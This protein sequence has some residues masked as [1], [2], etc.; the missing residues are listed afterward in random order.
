MIRLNIGGTPHDL[1]AEEAKQLVLSIAREIDS[2]GQPQRFSGTR[3]C[4]S[5]NSPRPAPGKNENRSFS[6]AGILLTDC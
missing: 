6:R 2:P 5:V 4:F 1:S 3:T